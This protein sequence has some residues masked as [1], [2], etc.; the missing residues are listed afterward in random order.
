MHRRIR[1]SVRS[2]ASTRR[3]CEAQIFSRRLT[4]HHHY[5]ASQ[6]AWITSELDRHRIFVFEVLGCGV[7]GNRDVP[8]AQRSPLIALRGDGNTEVR[9]RIARALG[10][11]LGAYLG[12]LRGA[13]AQC[14]AALREEIGEY[15]YSA[16]RDYIR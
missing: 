9:M 13:A 2:C 14:D 7:H 4:S 12:R 6:Q 11:P 15:T 3:Q 8:P 5:N 16:D 1:P 10:V